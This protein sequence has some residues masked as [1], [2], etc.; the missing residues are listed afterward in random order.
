[1][2]TRTPWLLAGAALALYA[3][4]GMAVAAEPGPGKDTQR[5]EP[6]EVLMYGHGSPKMMAMHG[7]ARAD[8][9]RAVLQLRTDQEPALKAYL[10]ATAPAHGAVGADG[11]VHRMHGSGPPRTTPERLAAMEAKM[12]EHLAIVKRHIAATR[13]FYGQLDAKQQKAF[14]AVSMDGPGRGHPGGMRTKHRMHQPDVPPEAP[15]S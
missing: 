10:D 12:T 14:D 4:A 13:T 6:R 3:S 8:R 9:M 7:A 15:R 2:S 5:I 11:P 1:M